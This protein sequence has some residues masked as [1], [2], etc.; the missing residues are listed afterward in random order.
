MHV[1]PETIQQILALSRVKCF[2]SGTEYV[3]FVSVALNTRSHVVDHSALFVASPKRYIPNHTAAHSSL[4][5]IGLTQL[6]P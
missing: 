3:M 6:S 5:Q 4:S 2:R 1:N